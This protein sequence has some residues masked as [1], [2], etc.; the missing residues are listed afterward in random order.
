M[1]AK[2]TITQKILY[3]MIAGLITG[4]LINTFVADSLW[5]QAYLVQGLFKVIGTIFI[6]GLKMLVVYR[7]V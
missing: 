2:T 6:N 1:L 7:A 4:S 3:A 5:V